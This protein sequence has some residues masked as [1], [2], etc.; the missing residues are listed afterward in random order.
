MATETFL[1]PSRF[2]IRAM[3]LGLASIALYSLSLGIGREDL[4]V[5]G[6]LFGLGILFMVGSFTQLPK[7]SVEYIQRKRGEQYIRF[8]SIFQP[9][10]FTVLFSVLAGM[11]IFLYRSGIGPQLRYLFSMILE[12]LGLLL[13]LYALIS[14]LIGMLRGKS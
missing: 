8:F 11:N 12:G 6:F 3:R 13:N 2:L 4:P 14:N 10:I 9:L 1:S 7:V 5:K